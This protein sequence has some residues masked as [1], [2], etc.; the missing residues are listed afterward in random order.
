MRARTTRHAAAQSHG[1]R[2][3]GRRSKGTSRARSVERAGPEQSSGDGSFS[4][5][6][7]RQRHL[8]QVVE[9]AMSL[10]EE[11]C[12]KC[13]RRLQEARRTGACAPGDVIPDWKD[14][15][16]WDLRIR[17][18]DPSVISDVIRDTAARLLEA[19]D[20]IDKAFNLD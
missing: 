6:K 18:G 11:R 5:G 10:A 7:A 13:V 20:R 19:A 9:R 2:S 1:G 14:E 3:H 8:P 12:W 17:A 4:A 16:H 15:S